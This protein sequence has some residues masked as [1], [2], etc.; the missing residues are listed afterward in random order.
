MRTTD[1]IMNFVKSDKELE[2]FILGHDLDIFIP[3]FHWN[4]PLSYAKITK[5]TLIAD[6]KVTKKVLIKNG[7]NCK[8]YDDDEPYSGTK[9]HVWQNV[10]KLVR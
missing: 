4:K 9:Y 10:L 6:V 2:I 3:M 1:M 7:R 5:D 8:T